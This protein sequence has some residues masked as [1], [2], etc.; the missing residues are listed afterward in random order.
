ML[1]GCRQSGDYVS[2]GVQDMSTEINCL[3][4]VLKASSLI[5]KTQAPL[6][7]FLGGYLLDNSIASES[8]YGVMVSRARC[9]KCRPMVVLE[10]VIINLSMRS[11]SLSSICG[12]FSFQRCIVT[13]SLNKS[14]L[15][16]RISIATFVWG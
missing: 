14:I 5:C 11:D 3:D 15:L 4:T 13:S 9:E 8:I 7:W 1:G 10:Q 16:V 12:C 6:L 2:S